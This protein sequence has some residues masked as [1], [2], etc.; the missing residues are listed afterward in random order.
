VSVVYL[1]LIYKGVLERIFPADIRAEYPVPELID[2]VFAKTGSIN[3]VT[4]ECL[5]VP[6]REKKRQFQIRII[7]TEAIII[8]KLNNK[9]HNKKPIK[10]IKA[11][12][13]LML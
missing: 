10:T 6:K 9:Y 5:L 3:S 7:K 2:P 1:I 13:D 4:D 12:S 8:A 11:P